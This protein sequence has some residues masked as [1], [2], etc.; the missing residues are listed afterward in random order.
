MIDEQVKDVTTTSLPPENADKGST[1]EPTTTS[2]ESTETQTEFDAKAEIAALREQLTNQGRELGQSRRLQ[3]EMAELRK[4]LDGGSQKTNQSQ[5]DFLGKYTPEQ[6]AESKQLIAHLWKE[7]YGTDWELL[8]A[9]QS[10]ARNER[11]SSVFESTARGILGKDYEAIA[12][13]ASN[14]IERAKEAKMN[15]DPEAQEFL[16]LMTS[17]P[18]IGARVLSYMAKESYQS[19]LAGKSQE[20]LKTQAQ[21]GARVAASSPGGVAGKTGKLD[22]SKMTLDQLRAAAE[23][24]NLEGRSLA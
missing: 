5:T 18:A 6:I 22:P 12:P 4:R 14:I 8:Q 21:T 19:S 15:G 3:S 11:V 9:E 10:E 17:K 24:E 7:Q 2:T 23:Q 16:D 13:I 1:A 20:A